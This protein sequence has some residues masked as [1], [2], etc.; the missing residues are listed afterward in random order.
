[1][2][3][4]MKIKMPDETWPL[5]VSCILATVVYAGKPCK[6]SDPV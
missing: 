4:L 5:V 3:Q 2:L 6:Y 1:M